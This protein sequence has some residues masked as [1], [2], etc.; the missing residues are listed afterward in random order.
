[1]LTQ[2]SFAQDDETTKNLMG[3]AEVQLF[4][5]IRRGGKFIDNVQHNWNLRCASVLLLQDFG[6]LVK[7]TELWNIYIY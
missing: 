5:E 3:K 7:L 2:N 6:T 1:M 4:L